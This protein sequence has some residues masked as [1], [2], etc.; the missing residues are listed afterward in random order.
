MYMKR[1][2]LRLVGAMPRKVRD[3]MLHSFATALWR[4][5]KEIEKKVGGDN[6]V[7]LWAADLRRR[8]ARLDSGSNQVRFSLNQHAASRDSR[9]HRRFQR[10]RIRTVARLL[11]VF[12]STS[13]PRRAARS[14]F[15]IAFRGKFMYE[16]KDQFRGCV[17]VARA[18][19]LVALISANDAKMRLRTLF[20]ARPSPYN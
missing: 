6:C 17:G 14:A 5:R 15:S 20:Y 19:K 4:K 13:C 10:S 16:I 3:W 8:P 1:N 18:V 9:K 11:Y 7:W 2:M 12:L